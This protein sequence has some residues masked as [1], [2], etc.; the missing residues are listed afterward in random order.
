[1]NPKQKD[2]IMIEVFNINPINRGDL[3][4]SCSVHIIPW[5]L[6]IH[7]INIFQK[8]AKQWISLPREKYEVSGETKY[9]D[10]LEFTDLGATKRFRDQIMDAVDS[11]I[12]KNGTLQ[13]EDVIKPLDDFPF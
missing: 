8:G 12:K 9:S 1:M 11:Y 4:A 3:L 6:K 13:P 2:F 10:L 7:K 5:K